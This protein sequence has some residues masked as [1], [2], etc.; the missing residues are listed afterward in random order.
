MTYPQVMYRQLF[1]RSNEGYAHIFK[2]TFFPPTIE[3]LGIWVSHGFS[4]SIRYI[5]MPPKLWSFYGEED[6]ESSNLH[7]LVPHLQTKTIGTQQWNHTNNGKIGPAVIQPPEIN[8]IGC[9]DPGLKMFEDVWFEI[10]S[11]Q[12]IILYIMPLHL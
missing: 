6:D 10:I 2:V 9:I 12:C 11:N 1:F 8:Q 4:M 3:S 5:G 7:V